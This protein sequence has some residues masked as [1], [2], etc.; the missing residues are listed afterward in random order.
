MIDELRFNYP[1]AK[2]DFLVNN[3][4]AELV[5]DYP[6]INKVHAI[7]KDSM[8]DIKRIC[9]ENAYDL[10][11][12]VHPTFAIAH[13]VFHGKVRFRLGTAYR[14][15][16][17]M[18]NIK[19]KQ[20]RK[21]S[22]QHELEYN[23]DLLNELGC[24]RPENLS[25]RLIVKDD[26]LKYINKR[27]SAS[28][29]NSADKLVAIHIPSLGSALVWSDW[30][31][32]ELIRLIVNN[33]DSGVKVVLTGT[34]ADEEQVKGVMGIVGGNN[35][36]FGL[37]DLNL[38]QLAA[39]YKRSNVFV[40]N[41]SGPIHIAA[42]VGTFVIGLYS[43]IKVESATR[44][45]PYTDKKKVFSPDTISNKPQVMD[46]IKPGEVFGAVKTA[47]TIGG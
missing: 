18:F 9:I 16:S 17:F 21:Y 42:A 40:G 46:K 36:V 47:L 45:G 15:Y 31:F 28:G 35:R 29:I 3:R 39:L 2:I 10:V 1:E 27:L 7:E 32:E 11:I 20:H 26:E 14:W 12:I 24:K 19:H 41:S 4:V 43:P 8:S 23:L 22:L 44:W 13:G 5:E 33:C 25:P 30:N 37:F 34:K 38:R 6:N